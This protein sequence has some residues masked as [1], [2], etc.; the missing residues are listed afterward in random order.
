MWTLQIPAPGFV[1]IPNQLRRA[2]RDAD[3][4]EIS[5]L[6]GRRIGPPM[7]AELAFA[8]AERTGKWRVIGRTSDRLARP[9]IDRCR[10][11]VGF[12]CILIGIGLR[13][14]RLLHPSVGKAGRWHRIA[15]SRWLLQRGIARRD[16]A[17]RCIAQRRRLCIRCDAR[18]RTVDLARILTSLPL[19]NVRVRCRRAAEPQRE[20]DAPS[21]PEPSST[22]THLAAD[23]CTLP[24]SPS[25]VLSRRSERGRPRITTRSD[26]RG[27][28]VPGESGGETPQP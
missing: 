12:A 23:S 16:F 26:V 14:V 28:V 13:C 25:A 8:R 27:C 11:V 15:L 19:R 17:S 6:T 7:R 18:P 5:V 24:E 3:A 20:R 22:H 1:T 9:G 10:C 4:R 21:A 2:G